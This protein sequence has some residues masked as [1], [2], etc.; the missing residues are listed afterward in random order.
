[1]AKPDAQFDRKLAAIFQ[2]E[3][4][5]HLQRMQTSLAGSDGSIA[6]KPLELLFRAAHS[7]KGAARAVGQDE[8]ETVCHAMEGVL[9]AVQRKR[10]AWSPAVGDALHDAVNGLERSL[11][12][13]VPAGALAALLPHLEALQASASAEAEA[14]VAAPAPAATESATGPRLPPSRPPMASRPFASVSSAWRGCCTTSK[15]W[16]PPSCRAASTWTACANCTL[17]SP[18]CAAS[19]PPPPHRTCR[20]GSSTRRCCAD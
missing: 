16:W 19:P 3:A 8:I 17:P 5:E 13:R 10:L 18:R 9:A 20:P 14:P 1:M 12:E 11:R 7:L 15:N 4:A 2:A 6:A